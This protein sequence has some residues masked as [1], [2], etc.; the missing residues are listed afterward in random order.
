MSDATIEGI[1]NSRPRAREA[2][3]ELAYT[4]VC[5]FCVF[6]MVVCLVLASALLRL[7]TPIVAA[8]VKE[9]GSTSFVDRGSLDLGTKNIEIGHL[10]TETVR[11]I[12]TATPANVEEF[13]GLA[14][15]R[16]SPDM[17][18]EFLSGVASPES[19]A[20]LKAADPSNHSRSVYRVMVREPL[21]TLEATDLPPNFRFPDRLLPRINQRFDV[22]V[23]GHIQTY[24]SMTHE[25]LR[26]VPQE[27]FAY[28]VR[29]QELDQRVE[30]WPQALM[31]DWM[32]PIKYRKVSNDEEGN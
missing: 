22:I 31:V 5:V 2:G 18:S 17:E 24:D 11:F 19:I 20:A 29:T 12:A 27:P 25:L 10:A 14:R 6:L 23:S 28:W 1:R 21:R 32:M 9:D 16:M 7:K 4:T 30:R 3:A 15:E 8:V 26:N 13:Y